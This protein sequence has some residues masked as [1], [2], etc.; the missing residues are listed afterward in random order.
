M[1]QQAGRGK[2]TSGGRQTAAPTGMSALQST[3]VPVPEQS[4]AFRQDWVEWAGIKQ[5]IFLFRDF[6]FCAC[7]D[8]ILLYMLTELF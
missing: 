1:A 4:E 8:F 2:T 7:L 5:A 3:T 6:C